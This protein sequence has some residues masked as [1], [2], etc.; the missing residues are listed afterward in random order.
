MLIS[1]PCLHTVFSPLLEAI[2][3]IMSLD[4]LSAELLHA[5]CDVCPQDA[6]QDLRLTCHRPREVADKH[7]FPEVVTCLE[8]E[9]LARVRSMSDCNQDIRNAVNS[10]TFQTDQLDVDIDGNPLLRREWLDNRDSFLFILNPQLSDLQSQWKERRK[11]Q[12]RLQ[13]IVAF[14]N[15]LSQSYAQRKDNDLMKSNYRTYKRLAADETELFEAYQE[16][17][18]DATPGASL[19]DDPSVVRHTVDKLF[20]ACANIRAITINHKDILR[21]NAGLSNSVFLKSAII[22]HGGDSSTAEEVFEA[23]LPAACDANLKI[24]DLAI[25]GATPHFMCATIPGGVPSPRAK[26]IAKYYQVLRHV[27]KLHIVFNGADAV[28]ADLN[29]DTMSG[30]HFHTDSFADGV[31]IDWLK[32]CPVIQEARLVMPIAPYLNWRVEWQYILGQLHLPNLRLLRVSNFQAEAQDLAEC[33]LRHKDSLEDMELENAH[34]S[35]GDWPSCISAFAGKLPRLRH[36][37]LIGLFTS[38]EADTEMTECFLTSPQARKHQVELEKYILSGAGPMP[39]WAAFDLSDGLDEDDE[40][41]DDEDEHVND[42]DEDDSIEEE[43]AEDDERNDESDDSHDRMHRDFMERRKMDTW[44][45]EDNVYV[46]DDGSDDQPD[47]QG[48]EEEICQELTTL[49]AGDE[50][51]S[52]ALQY[53]ERR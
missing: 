18:H 20:T 33:L 40:D 50:F 48:T 31:L 7:F 19:M 27:Q 11:A 36:A 17:P 29:P 49:P 45:R 3:W 34:L 42:E 28:P 6:L 38:D 22:P 32:H 30:F 23:I 4:D 16:T 24:R 37:R 51:S 13:H 5:I 10:F 43:D 25:A 44:E 12:H 39:T 53:L 52:W 26:F 2:V 14:G 46:E 21:R 41:E 1:S 47:W 9:D 35:E 8:R 15:S